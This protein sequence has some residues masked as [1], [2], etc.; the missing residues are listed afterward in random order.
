M[1]GQL[2]AAL[3]VNGVQMIATYIT[4]FIVD[5]VGRR[6]LLITGDLPLAAVSAQSSS[7]G[8]VGLFRHG[9]PPDHR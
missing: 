4:V 6:S 5:K 7:T 1:A 3:L 8:S 2:Y 9:L